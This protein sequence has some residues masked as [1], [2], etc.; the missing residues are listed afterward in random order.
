[1]FSFFGKKEKSGVNLEKI[2]NDNAFLVDVRSP[3]EFQQGSAKNAVNI[4]LGEV[5]QNIDIF[6]EHKHVVV[7]CRSG[8]RSG[9]AKKLLMKGGIDHVYNGGRWQ[10]VKALQH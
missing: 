5:L 7:F 4:P 10:D 6:K 3:G 1:M 8:N 9:T 2:I